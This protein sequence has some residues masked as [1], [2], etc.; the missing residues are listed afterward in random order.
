MYIELQH[1]E[2]SFGDF[3]A[4]DDVT[5]S[6]EKGKLI[7]LLGPSGSGKT[8]ILR[9]LAGLE[10]QDSGD[11]LIDG[12]NVN[13]LPPDERGV[14]FVFQSYA[15]FPYLNVFGNIAYGMKIQKK[16]KAFIKNRVAELLDLV[17]LPGLEKRYP[18]QLSGGQRQ[19]IALARALAPN[20]ELLLL[21]EPF[22]AIDAKVRKELRTWL[23]ETIDK[24]GITSIFVTHDQDE[25]IEV[26][27]E[28]VITN[29]G[30]VEQVGSPAEIYLNPKT[31]FVAKFI[32]QSNVIEHY[33][34]LKGFEHI[35][36]KH[37]AVIRPEFVE[38]HKF[39]D[40]SHHDFESVM[41]DGIVTDMFFRGNCFEVRVDAVGMNIA[42]KLPLGVT[43]IHK[44]DSVK[45]FIKQLYTFDDTSTETIT[46]KA[47][48]KTELYYI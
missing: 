29:N 9:I 21:D 8:T 15:L 19:R 7:G 25:A 26:A 38:I 40:D 44:G 22:A 39:S 33:S 43:D 17:G 31:P 24:I 11:I 23:R 16:D 41:E 5:F 45:V 47:L 12:R 14:G 37:N 2:K 4:S 3:K 36:G 35:K 18:D 6:V 13:A 46:N 42:G 1:I 48:D 27:D 32:G 10:K 20:P 34:K 28:I 30:R